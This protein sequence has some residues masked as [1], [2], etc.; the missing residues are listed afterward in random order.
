M[1]N[2]WMVRAGEGGYLAEDFA[3]GFVAIGW[4]KLGDMTKYSDQEVIS[5]E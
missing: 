5:R 2:V 1:E 4:S 3:K